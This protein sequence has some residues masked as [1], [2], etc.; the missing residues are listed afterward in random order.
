V[1]AGD[2]A[3][4]HSANFEIVMKKCNEKTLAKEKITNDDGSKIICKKPE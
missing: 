3:A 4:R 1:L 2:P